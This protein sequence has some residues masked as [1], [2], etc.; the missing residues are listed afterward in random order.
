MTLDIKKI[1][2]EH[3]KIMIDRGFDV[4]KTNMGQNLMLIV[5]ELGEALQAHRKENFGLEQKDTFEDELADTILRIFDL[6]EAC[7]I[8]IE[9]QILWKMNHNKTRKYENKNY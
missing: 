7:N 2:Q 6:C 1:S 5:T 3:H 9:K 4:S 8:D